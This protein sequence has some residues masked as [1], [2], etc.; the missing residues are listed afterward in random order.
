[1]SHSTVSVAAAADE[2]RS[3]PRQRGMRYLLWILLIA[4][5][6]LCCALKWGGYLLVGED[7]LPAHAAGAVVLQGSFLGERARLAGAVQLLQQGR[8]DRILL[9]VPHESYW[10]QPLF[11]LVQNFIERHYGQGIASR[12]DICD[13]S[14]VVDST[15]QEARVLTHCI[16]ERG[17]QSFVLVTSNYH[18]RRAGIIWR[19]VIREGHLPI[20]LSVHGVD[21]PE[22]HS[23]GWW[24]ERRSAK[25][26]LM[27]FVKLCSTIVS[28]PQLNPQVDHA[29]SPSS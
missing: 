20:D 11:P 27:E 22:F 29:A 17:W 5:V 18:T 26:W 4:I 1:V 28:A 6:T 12:I 25:T 2:S 13:S 9:S 7:P 8:V 19:R 10:G 21:D 14:P 23:A 3:R 24:R 16:Q 15:E